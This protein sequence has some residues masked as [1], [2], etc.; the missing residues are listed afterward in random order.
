MKDT[1]LLKVDGL[2]LCLKTGQQARQVVDN[3]SFTLQ[4]NRILGL[5]GESGCGKS[6][7]CLAVMRLLPRAIQQTCG[8]IEFDEQ[9]IDALPF[10]RMRTIRGRALAM[11]MQNP[12]S[13]FDAVFTVGEHFKETLASHPDKDSRGDEERIHDSLHAVGFNDPQ[14]ILGLYPFQMSGGMLQRA[15][16]ALALM[17]N[18][19]LL[20]ADEPTTDLDVIAQAKVLDL[21][22]TIRDAHGMAILLVTHDLGVIARLADDVAVMQEGQI[23]E[24]GIA[25]EIFETSRHPYTRELINAH[26][27]LYDHRLN[28]I[29]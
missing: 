1:H 12:M 29:R 17:M 14:S 3:L 21:L 24:T 7:T 13:C 8:T 10:S 26:L 5:I 6:L 11:I 2:S 19:K 27:E 18:V 9:S 4:A 23:I 28:T 25:A 15:M 20:I 22:D 16:V